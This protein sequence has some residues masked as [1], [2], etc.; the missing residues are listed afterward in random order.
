MKGENRGQI[1][2]IEAFLAAMV[3]FAGFAVSSNLTMPQSVKKS[4]DL[5]NVGLQA[6][7]VLDS[8]GSLDAYI[9]DANWSGLRDALSAFLPIGV[10]FNLTVY[11]AQMQQLNDVAISNGGFSSQRI[12]FTEYVCASRNPVFRCYVVHLRMAVAT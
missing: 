12:A 3:I 7:M 5:S 2:I 10:C 9:S 8:D 1:R 6:L 11:D 4:G